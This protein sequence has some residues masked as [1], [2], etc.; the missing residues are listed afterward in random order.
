MVLS[1]LSWFI[2]RLTWVYGRH[3]YTDD[4]WC[5]FI[6]QLA[7]GGLG[8]TRTCISTST[9][10]PMFAAYW[11]RLHPNVMMSITSMTITSNGPQSKGLS[12]FF[13]SN[14]GSKILIICQLYIWSIPQ[15]PKKKCK[16]QECVHK[17]SPD[18]RA[19]S[20]CWTQPGTSRKSLSIGQ[21]QKRPSSVVRRLP[22]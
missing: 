2:S 12:L 13:S 18:S 14:D 22:Q 15:V 19:L 5:G 11:S 9:H 16:W 6:N 17:T 1:Q 20:H 21:S 4:Y 7:T 10:I 3:V 8:G